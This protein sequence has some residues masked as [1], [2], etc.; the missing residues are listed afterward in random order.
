MRIQGRTENRPGK[1]IFLTGNAFGT[2]AK[3]FFFGSGNTFSSSYRPS[4]E[5]QEWKHATTRLAMFID[6]I[7]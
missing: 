5:M 6:S 7:V 1:L 3:L 2:V 4:E